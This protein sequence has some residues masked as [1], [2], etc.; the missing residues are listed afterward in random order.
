M[1]DEDTRR[2]ARQNWGEMTDAQKTAWADSCRAKDKHMAR[3]TSLELVQYRELSWKR[4]EL[5]RELRDLEAKAE[6]YADWAKDT[7]PLL[8]EASE[9]L[10]ACQAE[11]EASAAARESRS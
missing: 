5:Q 6:Q 9:A 3:F 10:R 8:D 7:E 1:S 2:E 11:I 4:D